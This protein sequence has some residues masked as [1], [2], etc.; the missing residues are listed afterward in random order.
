[1]PVKKSNL[2]FIFLPLLLALLL[3]G[4]ALGGGAFSKQQAVTAAQEAMAHLA[5]GEDEKLAQKAEGALAAALRQGYAA[6]LRS[7]TEQAGSYI[8]LRDISV[9][10][11]EDDDDGLTTTAVKATAVY[12]K[13][14]FH[15]A[16]AFDHEGGLVGLALQ[17]Q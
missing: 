17:P 12:E 1:M 11:G 3:C 9:A 8:E 2:L 5:A 15:F 16:A 7:A 13:G 6:Q 14:A 10:S 4:C